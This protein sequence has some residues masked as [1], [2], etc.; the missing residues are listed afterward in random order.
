MSIW[1]FRHCYIDRSL[2]FYY[3]VI[4]IKIN[5]ILKSELEEPPCSLSF[6]GSP[7]SSLALSC[8]SLVRQWLDRNWLRECARAKKGAPHLAPT[9]RQSAQVR[10]S[11]TRAPTP[12]TNV[13]EQTKPLAK[14]WEAPCSILAPAVVAKKTVRA[15][16]QPSERI[17]PKAIAIGRF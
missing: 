15:G 2:S 14:E 10:I 16:S 3:K 7:F 17:P 12:K 13:Q 1:L 4:V 6:I 11:T 9:A 5:R 8:S